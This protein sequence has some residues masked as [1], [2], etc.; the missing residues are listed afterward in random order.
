VQ[1]KTAGHHMTK[2]KPGH[3]E[4]TLVD[5]RQAAAATL[6]GGEAMQAQ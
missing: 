1:S 5:R 3:G 2:P 4:L 6:I